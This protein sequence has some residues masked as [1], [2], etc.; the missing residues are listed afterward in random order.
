MAAMVDPYQVLRIRRGASLEEIRLS[1]RRAALK[2]HPD[3]CSGDPT[4]AMSRFIELCKAYESISGS[5]GP[6]GRVR[7]S[8]CNSPTYNPQD[9]ARME[10]SWTFVV[11][12][13]EKYRAPQPTARKLSYASVNETKVFVWFWVLGIVLS[14]VVAFCVAYP[15]IHAPFNREANIRCAL[16]LVGL[17]LGIYAAAI[18]ATLSSLVLRRKVRWLMS[19]LC[20]GT[21]LA[22]PPV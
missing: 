19:R 4:E 9:F 10:L 22:L 11:S 6:A 16:T 15:Y 12:Q 21:R 8:C 13:D 18:A 20:F 1:Y 2:H 7:Q 14:L 17:G 3:N 5:F